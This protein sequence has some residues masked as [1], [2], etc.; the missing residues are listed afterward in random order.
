MSC[1][2]GIDLA[3]LPPS[4][5]ALQMHIKRANFQAHIWRLAN[6]PIPDIPSPVGRG[7][8]KIRKTKSYANG[9]R[10]SVCQQ[11]LQTWLMMM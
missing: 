4:K 10:E 1:D 7:W 2:V 3:L 9:S 11:I 5:R 6:Q 8:E